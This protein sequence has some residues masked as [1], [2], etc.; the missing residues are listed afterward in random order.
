[1]WPSREEN[2][3]PVAE[4]SL[5]DRSSDLRLHVQVRHRV[6]EMIRRAPASS[7]FA[8][9]SESELIRMFGV[10][11]ITVRRA[12]A[13]LAAAGYIVRQ[14]GRGSYALPNKIRHTSGRIGGAS[15]EFR[16]QGYDVHARVITFEPREAPPAVAV[17]LSVQ[18]GSILPY[19]KRVMVAGDRPISVVRAYLNLPDDARPTLDDVSTESIVKVLR[20]KWGIVPVRAVR[21]MEAGLA[22]EDD[23]NLMKLTAPAAVLIAEM[24]AF[25]NSGRGFTHVNV[26]YDSAFY[27][28]VQ[29]IDLSG[30]NM[31]S[32]SQEEV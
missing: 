25:D 3:L 13:D 8:L 22:T 20:R 31:S 32:D 15:E 10:S 29:N 14:P 5:V 24:V 18:A 12:L 7:P 16:A 17:S 30:S 4:L 6:M 1:M 21:T 11:R 28:Y 19:V 27:R 26:R 23:Q 9:P 2:A